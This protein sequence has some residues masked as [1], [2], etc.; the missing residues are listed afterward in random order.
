MR[1]L[2]H[3]CTERIWCFKASPYHGNALFLENDGVTSLTSFFFYPFPKISKPHMPSKCRR[4]VN[5]CAEIY[6]SV[7]TEI[8]KETGEQVIYPYSKTKQKV[9]TKCSVRKYFSHNNFSDAVKSF[10]QIKQNAGF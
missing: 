4:K 10:F 6:Q 5:G 7:K 8:K 2:L 3:F 9:F 1:L